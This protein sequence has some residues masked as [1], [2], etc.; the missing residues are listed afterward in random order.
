MPP[1]LAER[2]ETRYPSTVHGYT[3]AEAARLRENPVENFDAESAVQIA[4]VASL[5]GTT[6]LGIADRREARHEKI[7]SKF[8]KA[9]QNIAQPETRAVGITALHNLL[10]Q[11]RE[12]YYPEIF[13]FTVELLKGR[14]ITRKEREYRAF[15]R[16]IGDLFR[17]CAP[18][19][20]KQLHMDRLAKQNLSAE[21]R[22]FLNQQRREL[23][24]ASGAQLQG[25]N[26]EFAN[27][28]HL[29]LEGASFGPLDPEE[30]D[31]EDE[32]NPNLTKLYSANF[33][34]ADLNRADFS[35]VYASDIIFC[36]A[37]VRR[38]DFT[39]AKLNQANFT[40]ANLEYTDLSKANK[41]NNLILKN[42]RNYQG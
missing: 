24:D 18:L 22:R 13:R 37:R 10:T 28:A 8:E 32:E 40:G 1:E 30:I 36:G 9:L 17:R 31:L 2:I 3:P 15:Y 25:L 21:E 19:L 39:G 26:F 7:D 42:V 34:Y 16:S 27:F 38:A 35:Y 6:I 11:K 12:Q 33:S 20:S 5:I 23:L 4:T 41:T 29:L 14:D